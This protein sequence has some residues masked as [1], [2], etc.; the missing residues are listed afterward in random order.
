MDTLLSSLS[1]L[2]SIKLLQIGEGLVFWK[3]FL[4]PDNYM[5]HVVVYFKKLVE[6]NVLSTSSGAFVLT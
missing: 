3:L 6:L 2:L 1:T 4:V 5:Y